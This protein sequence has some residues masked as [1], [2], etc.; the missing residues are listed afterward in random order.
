MRWC[1]P[2]VLTLVPHHFSCLYG[3]NLVRTHTLPEH[4]SIAFS[5][6]L[7]LSQDLSMF[8]KAVSRVIRQP[9]GARSFG[10]EIKQVARMATC[11]VSSEVDAETIDSIIIGKG[12][13]KLKQLKGFAGI[14]RYFCKEHLDYKVIWP[15]GS[16]MKLILFWCLKNISQISTLTVG[17]VNFSEQIIVSFQGLQNFKTYM[18][19]HEKDMEEKFIE[20]S[21]LSTTSTMEF[22][23]FVSN[24]YGSFGYEDRSWSS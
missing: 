20:A 7:S 15:Y 16:T 22:Q 24:K 21:K 17:W 14:E 4:S 12:L 11:K 1:R 10:I 8:R 3:C 2:Y 6:T 5:G 9:L 13:P 23:N 18:E 19:V